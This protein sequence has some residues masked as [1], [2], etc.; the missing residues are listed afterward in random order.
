MNA[1]PSNLLSVILPRFQSPKIQKQKQSF[2]TVI[3][4]WISVHKSVVTG[5]VEFY[6]PSIWRK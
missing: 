6:A 1:A 3:I 2:F 5:C 4:L